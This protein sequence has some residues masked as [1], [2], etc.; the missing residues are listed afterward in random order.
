MHFLN[1]GGTLMRHANMYVSFTQRLHH[2][3][4]AFASECDDRHVALVGSFD[5]SQDIGR[6]TAGSN[7]QQDISRLAQCANLLRKN[8]VVVVIVGNR[9]QDRAVSSQ[10]N[11][12]Q[13]RPFTLKTPD[14]L[15]S[16]MLCVCC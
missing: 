2:L 9:R 3:A 13:L 4:T 7:S 16:E 14:K 6:V 11:S 12:T 5:S 10:S 8:L 1:S 15:S